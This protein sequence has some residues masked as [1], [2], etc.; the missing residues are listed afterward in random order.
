[1][2]AEG[3]TFRRTGF[4]LRILPS[5]GLLIVVNVLVR[6]QQLLAL[7]IVCCALLLPYA[8]VR[9]LQY[10]TI[11]SEAI[12]IGTRFIAEITVLKAELVDCR[13]IRLSI[14]VT[15]YVNVLQLIDKRLAVRRRSGLI[16]SPYGWG[17]RRRELFTQLGR[18]LMTSPV[19]PGEEVVDFI[20]RY[21]R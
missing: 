1:M 11:S 7:T 3:E 15:L 17:K 8:L 5:L 9:S 4:A 18:W 6:G 19:S 12:T 10:V 20:A 2:S 13:R 14:V 21:S 16:I